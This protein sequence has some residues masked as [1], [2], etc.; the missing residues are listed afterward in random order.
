MQAA[1]HF[2]QRGLRKYLYAGTSERLGRLLQQKYGRSFR[3]HPGATAL[4]RKGQGRRRS[5]QVYGHV[6]RIS[7]AGVAQLP[8]KK[9]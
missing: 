6:T 2:T 4:P 3:F 9:L 1:R 5:E 8:M 7:F